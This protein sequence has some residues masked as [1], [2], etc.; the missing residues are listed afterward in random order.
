MAANEGAAAEVPEKKSMKVAGARALKAN[1][2]GIVPGRSQRDVGAGHGNHRSGIP[3][4]PDCHGG[5]RTNKLTP[6]PP[7]QSAALL[8]HV[9][10]GQLSFHTFSGM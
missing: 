1:E 8:P 4:T 10:A 5:L 2:V 7:D 9:E 3:A 6:P